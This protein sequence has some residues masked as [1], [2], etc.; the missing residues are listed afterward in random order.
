M[1]LLYSI[2]FYPNIDM[3]IPRGDLDTINGP[4]PGSL[5]HLMDLQQRVGLELALV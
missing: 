4:P 5:G 2:V 3:P 1:G